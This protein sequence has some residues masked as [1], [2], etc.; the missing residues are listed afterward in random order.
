MQQTVRDMNNV[1]ADEL[2]PNLVLT[3]VLDLSQ[4]RSQSQE[5]AALTKVTPITAA[6]SYGQAAIISG[7][8]IAA[9]T[10]AT[11]AV[12]VGPSVTF[13]QNNYSPEA[14]SEIEIYRQTKNQLSQ[15][16]SAL[17]IT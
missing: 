14:L 9:Q 10:E 6:A 17:A 8:Q 3:P 13:E 4:V 15:L 16:K 11:A 1:V 12:A 5:L 2:D 7:Q